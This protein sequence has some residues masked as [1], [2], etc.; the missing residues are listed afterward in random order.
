MTN[1]IKQKKGIIASYIIYEEDNPPH[2]P[3]FLHLYICVI[4]AKVFH[5]L[6]YYL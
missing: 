1:T 6:K 5:I 3:E 2:V 4:F